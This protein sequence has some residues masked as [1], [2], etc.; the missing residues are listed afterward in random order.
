MNNE[1]IIRIQP[2]RN[3]KF[4]NSFKRIFDIINVN[5]GLKLNEIAAAIGEECFIP[6]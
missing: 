3:S 2:N 1:I 6:L 4:I 5:T